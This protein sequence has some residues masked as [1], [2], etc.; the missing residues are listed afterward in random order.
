MQKNGIFFVIDA[1]R[2]DVIS[3]IEGARDVAPN[4][5]CLADRGCAIRTVANAQATQFVLPALFTQTYPLD[6][7]GYNTGI[8]SRPCSYAEQLREAGYS[9][10]MMASCNVLGI[11]HGYDRGFDGMHTAID[12]R[13]VLAHLIGRNLHYNLGEWQR[14][15]ITESDILRL[16]EKEF[17]ALLEKVA[18]IVEG[19]KG[20]IW[21]LKLRKLN[22]RVAR[23]CLAELALFKRTPLAVLKKMTTV[24]PVLYWRYLGKP[25]P[26]V[27]YWFW[28]VLEA[29]RWRSEKFFANYNFP[30]LFLAQFETK[31]DEL[32]GPL[33]DFVAKQKGPWS[34]HLHLM[35]LHDSRSLSRPSH[36]LKRLAVWPRW[37]LLRLQGKTKRRASYDTALM[38]LDSELGK[39]LDVMRQQKLLDDTVFLVTGD[40]GCFY[41]GS[42]RPRGNVARRTHFEDIDIPLILSG[43]DAIPEKIGM[44]DSMGMTAT[45]LEALNVSPHESFKGISAFKGGRTAVISESAG[46][47]N[48]D[49]ARRDLYFTVTTE[50]HRMMSVLKD[51]NLEIFGLYDCLTDP[52]EMQDVSQDAA[53]RPVIDALVGHLEQER[54]EIL[55]MRGYKFT[56][57][58]AGR[59]FAAEQQTAG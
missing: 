34:I 38:L 48:A 22:E 4:L 3:D 54:G 20:L 58:E 24:P 29:A 26:G 2:Y 49:L 23:G 53:Q 12:T 13:V 50:Q 52:E 37:F 33:C 40:H 55:S 42:P 57:P 32:M 44:M 27:G 46:S 43:C 47:G 14:G 21:S 35:D 1:L 59:Q 17:V 15:E 39:L 9:T 56:H 30:F 28:R 18:D 31:A 5:A 25:A 10:Q 45:Y 41:A 6:H 7:G 16:L 19:G 11:T 36:I 51:S 8:R